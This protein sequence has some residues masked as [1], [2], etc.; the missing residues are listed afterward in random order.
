MSRAQT[1]DEPDDPFERV[2]RH[3]DKIEVL[4]ERD[5]RLGAIA[6]YVLAVSK[7]EKPDPYDARLAGLPEVGGGDEQ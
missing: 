4:C 5:D 3:E 1:Y 6:R 2:R 7:E